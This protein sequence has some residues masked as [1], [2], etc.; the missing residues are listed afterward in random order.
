VFQGTIIPAIGMLI[1]PWHIDL[2]SAAGASIVLTL[3]GAILLSIL[4]AT[5]RLQPR[6][7]LINTILYLTFGVYIAASFA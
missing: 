3:I 6:L 7:L 5:G 1:M 2:S 4:H